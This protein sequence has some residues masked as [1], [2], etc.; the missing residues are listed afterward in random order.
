MSE[1]YPGIMIPVPLGLHMIS[2]DDREI[3][4]EVS[5]FEARR[6][7]YRWTVNE[8]TVAYYDALVC[9]WKRRYGGKHLPRKIITK[10]DLQE[11]YEE[12]MGGG[13]DDEI[14]I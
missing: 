7:Y 12:Y 10:D 9:E 8:A 2:V 4:D 5:R 6:Q 1:K 11:F 3:I 14:E 13:F